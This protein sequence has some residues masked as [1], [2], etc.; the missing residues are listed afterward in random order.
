MGYI[1]E[2]YPL[3]SPEYVSACL[4]KVKCLFH[5]TKSFIVPNFD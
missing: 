1:D 5:A 3:F 2:V 4:L